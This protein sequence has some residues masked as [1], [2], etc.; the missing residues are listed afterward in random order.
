MPNITA[1]ETVIPA[2]VMP[3]LILLRIHTDEGLI[4]CGET[5][6]TP[7]AIE[8]LVHD[9]MAERLIGADARRIEAHWRF[10][11]ERCTAFGSPGAEMRALS[12][13]D[14]AER[15][16][17]TIHCAL[18]YDKKVI[19]AANTGRPYVMT[20]GRLFNRFAMKFKTLVDELDGLGADRDELRG[21]ASVSSAYNSVSDAEIT[22][23]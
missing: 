4:G 15:L 19:A 9:W 17:C 8:A 5:Y 23:E 2:D 20:A 1:I 21:D 16:N 10:L 18:P 3:N 22:D 6:Y 11:Y 7:Q 12:A 13:I 14:V